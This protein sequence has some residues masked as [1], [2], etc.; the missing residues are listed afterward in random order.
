MLKEFFHRMY[1]P[2]RQ[3]DFYHLLQYTVRFRCD[4]AG[5]P[6]PNGSHYAS[7]FK[8][9]HRLLQ[10]AKVLIEQHGFEPPKLSEEYAMTAIFSMGTEEFLTRNKDTCFMLESTSE[11]LVNIGFPLRR[12]YFIL[13]NEGN[14]I[15]EDDVLDRSIEYY[16]DEGQS[17]N[18]E[19]DARLRA[20]LKRPRLS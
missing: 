3:D 7:A 1:F 15:E 2:E 11:R 16:H 8:G 19:D 13:I 6:M 12:N 17:F 4:S 18:D 5:N 10:E 20:R 14:V 9:N